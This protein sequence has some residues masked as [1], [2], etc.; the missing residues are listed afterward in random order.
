MLLVLETDE[1]PTKDAGVSPSVRK[2][3]RRILQK[4]PIVKVKRIVAKTARTASPINLKMRGT[5]FPTAE[6][7]MT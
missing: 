4:N 1:L 2:A 7:I 5:K 3:H 6:A